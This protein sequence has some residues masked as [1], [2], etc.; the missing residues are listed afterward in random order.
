MSR[1]GNIVGVGW[2]RVGVRGGINRRKNINRLG[3]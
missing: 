1:E 3:R 2:G